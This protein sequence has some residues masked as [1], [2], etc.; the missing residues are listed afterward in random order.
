MT[1]ILNHYQNLLEKVQKIIQETQREIV[2]TVNREKVEMCWEIGKII[3][4]HLL[5]NDRADYGEKLFNQ[6]AK[7]ISIS[8]RTLYQMRAFYKAYPILP[9]SENGLNW[10]HYRNLVSVKDS[11]K[12][13]YLEDLTVTEKLGAKNLQHEIV[14]SK[15]RAKKIYS[16]EKLKITRGKVFTYKLAKFS[17][18]PAAFVDCG[19]KVF[20]EI[21]TALKIDGEI[22]ESVKK[23]DGFA[24]KKSAANS[25]QIYTYKAFLDRVVDGDTIHVTLDLGFKARHQEI[26][27]LAKIGA[28]EISTPEGKK[29][30][31]AL[32]EILKDAP[33]LVVKTN[34]TD[35]YGRYIADVFF[36]ESGETEVQKV[37]DSG[38]YLNQLLLERGLVELY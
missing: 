30:A 25:K 15:P 14:K 6:L 20:L 19:F 37:A 22:I 2:Q 23:S 27:R 28:A 32:Q 4:E 13:K 24:L 9:A 18:S 7:D 33:F 3:D 17:D 8:K 11:E 1:V 34:K 36:G 26:L 5:K 21:K 31:K 12:R 29:A 38:T 35:I 10:S 16:G